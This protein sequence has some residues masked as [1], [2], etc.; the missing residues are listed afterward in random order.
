M[1]EPSAVIDSAGSM[2]SRVSSRAL[3]VSLSASNAGRAGAN[4]SYS[5]GVWPRRRLA[6]GEFLL[7]VRLRSVSRLKT[8]HQATRWKPD[9]AARSGR[10]VSARTSHDRR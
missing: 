8:R 9:A 6:S 7:T 5:R 2:C 4:R 3:K 10:D 1:C